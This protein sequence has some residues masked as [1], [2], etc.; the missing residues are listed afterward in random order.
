M[1]EA[2]N[3]CTLEDLSSNKGITNIMWN[4]RSLF[5]KFA[6]IVHIV[7]TSQADLAIFVESWLTSSISDNMVELEGFNII[8]QDR[9][10]N[11]NKT[12]GGGS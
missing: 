9:N 5:G 8:R 7:D 11:S 1:G 4:C 6:E 3:I 12:R 10:L 2:N